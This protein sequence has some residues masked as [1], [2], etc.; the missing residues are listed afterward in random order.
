MAPGATP[1]SASQF[2]EDALIRFESRDYAGAIIQ[3]KNALKTNPKDLPS[4][5]LLG[6]SFLKSGNAIAAEYELR[7]AREQ[8]ADSSI[9]SVPLADAFL[10]QGKFQ[11]LEEELERGQRN[12]DAEAR[13]LMIS[14]I[15]YAQQQKFTQADLAFDRAAILDPGNPAPVVARA[16]LAFNTGKPRR[17]KDLLEYAKSLD[18]A[19]PEVW[20]LEGQI[21]EQD[22]DYP[23]ALEAY[24]RALAVNPELRD[25]RVGRAAVLLM[26]GRADE[27]ASSL[28][29]IYDP[30]SFNPKTS[31]VYAM[32]LEANGEKA[33]SDEVL[34]DASDSLGRATPEF[35]DRHST[36]LILSTQIAFRQGNLERAAEQARKTILA[37]P[38]H[39]Q[40]RILLAQI[41]VGQAEFRE[42]LQVLRPAMKYGK[43]DPRL[44]SFYGDVL[45]RNHRFDEA[46][47]ILGRAIQLAPDLPILHT[48]L[49]RSLLGTGSSKSA[50]RSLK[51][52]MALESGAAAAGMLLG[53]TQLASA[54]LEGAIETGKRMLAADPGN[55][56]VL[57]LMGAAYTARGEIDSAHQH[58]QDALQSDPEFTPAKLN[59][60]RLYLA[61]R[62]FKAA[63][64]GFL[65]V[66]RSGRSNRGAMS[67]LADIS[68]RRGDLDG[69][70]E[71]LE[72]LRAMDPGAVKP[73]LRLVRLLLHKNNPKRAL[74]VAEE[75]AQRHPDEFNVQ[76]VLGQVQL[77]HGQRRRARATYRRTSTIA[78]YSSK[79]LRRLAAHQ[80][81]VDDI[82]GS[83]WS[84]D[85]AIKGAPDD[86]LARVD[87]IKLETRV[88]N[89]DKALELVAA[90]TAPASDPSFPDRLRADVLVA[91]GRIEQAVAALRQADQ[92][93]ASGETKRRL[94]RAL[95]LVGETQQAVAVL[96]PWVK[97]N[98]GDVAARHALAVGY[99]KAGRLERALEMHRALLE[100][101]PEEPSLHNNLALIYLGLKDPRALEYARKAYDLAPKDSAILDTYGW[102]MVQQGSTQ[103]GLALLRDALARAS[104]DLTTRYHLAVAL[105]R[106]DRVKEAREVLGR[107]LESK[108]PF[109]ERDQARILLNSLG[110]G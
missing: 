82:E 23:L 102:V 46:V 108:L 64:D 73:I 35:L 1:E 55:P 43:N 70:I 6:K 86:L 100:K 20:Q 57:N 17:A 12:Q 58:F 72:K 18:D 65:D 19:N 94:F 33:R 83:R 24:E 79:D 89:H 99:L 84:L 41:L 26:T 11:E 69:S 49:A 110:S 38:N 59:V 40:A 51:S 34:H 15:G 56:S 44:L 14:G 106:L 37:L 66:L 96:E 48:Q 97:R 71:W 30:D 85:K 75:L 5:I 32:A 105:T 42:A 8:G 7:I 28:V 25:A 60:A 54:D 76:L 61:A 101:L 39:P 27:A 80:L 31:Y 10:K 104:E 36:L 3:L 91:K 67:G 2:Y 103:E 29:D 16:A 52:A 9:V 77:A 92:L 98:P 45:L 63:E 62:R 22:V 4:R 81:Q 21:A 109:D 107:L 13:I 53:Y 88:G 78:G 87:S 95:L 68:A 74:L 90:L 93:A 50:I 47:R